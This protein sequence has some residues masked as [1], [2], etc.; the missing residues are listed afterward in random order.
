M[1]FENFEKEMDVNK[2]RDIMFSG[3]DSRYTGY[4]GEGYVGLIGLFLVL[5]KGV[6]LC[7]ERRFPKLPVPSDEEQEYLAHVPG[8][9][10][11]DPDTAKEVIRTIWHVQRDLPIC[12]SWKEFNKWLEARK[13]F[14]LYYVMLEPWY[15]AGR[16]DVGL[17]EGEEGEEWPK[18]IIAVEI[19]DTYIDKPLEA[20]QDSLKEL[21]V[22]PYPGWLEPVQTYYVF[23]RGINW[24]KSW[25]I[26]KGEALRVLDDLA[27]NEYTKNLVKIGIERMYPNLQEV[28]HD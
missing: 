2:L 1:V 25:W 8:R 10:T 23:R 16:A 3:G 12:R 24:G 19:G 5:Q 4:F 7:E 11:H 6:L 22:V 14:P 21:W 27:L 17:V 28:K 20:F 13:P 9:L 18:A 26:D 15:P